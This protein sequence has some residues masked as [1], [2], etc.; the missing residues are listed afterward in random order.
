[1]TATTARFPR[2]DMDWIRATSYL[3]MAI[4]IGLALYGSLATH[5]FLT[6]ANLRSVLSQSAFVGVFAVATAIIMISGN[7][8][9]LSIAATGAV[10]ASAAL[11]LLPNGGAVAIVLT[12]LLGVAIFIPQGLLIGG[13]GANPIIVSIAFGGLEE[14]IFLWASHGATI[15]PPLGNTSFTWLSTLVN[16][17]VIGNLP[18]AVFILIGVTAALECVLR[19]TRFGTM[20]YLVGENRSAARAAGIPTAWVIVG[21]F[22]LAGLCIAIAG[23]ELGAFNSAGSLL[24]ESNYT[25]DGIAAAVIGGIAITGGRGSL[26]QALG[27]AVLVQAISDIVLLRGYTEGWQ[28]LLKGLILLGVVV[29]MRLNRMRSAR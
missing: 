27:G 3:I 20:L 25:T 23:I 18:I 28:L 13:L 26:F 8:F 21:A 29:L 6:L 12:L 22:A 24:V 11:A 2:H 1:M 19:L 5:G 10:T 9:S 14:G 16:V 15:V 17:P 7:L 4:A